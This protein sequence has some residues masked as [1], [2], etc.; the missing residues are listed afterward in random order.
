[1]INWSVVYFGLSVLLPHDSGGFFEGNLYLLFFFSVQSQWQ[2][3]SGQ[4]V[5]EFFVF[6]QRVQWVHGVQL[7]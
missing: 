5:N 6:N 7:V 1:M 3:A 4:P 2:L